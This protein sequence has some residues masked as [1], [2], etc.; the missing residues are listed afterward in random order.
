LHTDIGHQCRGAKSG[1]T[2]L[3]LAQPLASGSTV[4]ILTGREGGPSR[5]WLNASLG[6]LRTASARAKV[7][8]W[9][10]ERDRS[11]HVAQGRTILDRELRRL[12]LDAV[13]LTDLARALHLA[14]PDE[15]LAAL[16]RSELTTAQIAQALQPAKPAQ[17]EEPQLSMARRV[18]GEA[19]GDVIV[20]GVTDVMT[21]TARCCSPVPGEPIGGYITVGQGVSIHRA[22]CTNFEKLTRE[23][24]ERIVEVSWGESAG[25]TH[26][27]SID[28][29][30]NDRRGLLR[31]VSDT[32]SNLKVDIVAVKT[33]SDAKTG[34]AHMVFTVLVA[35]VRQVERI[36]HRLERI[37]S[38]L[39][40]QRHA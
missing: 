25:A 32:L 1:G 13:K 30:A 6:Y 2:I 20:L 23:R 8:R 31:D 29:E 7:R 5:D 37:K 15:L 22:D 39:H 4:E 11:D 18:A 9:F 17:S 36:V 33:F 28:I 35:D 19:G 38:V 12:G 40:A 10:R 24:P 3:P 14:D 26:R 27:V 21:R 34:Q 16:G